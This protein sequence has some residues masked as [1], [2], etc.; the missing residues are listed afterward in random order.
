MQTVIPWTE[1]TDEQHI[2]WGEAVYIL[3]RDESD[4][5]RVSEGEC[6]GYDFTAI[7]TGVL[8]RSEI[9]A[10]CFIKDLKHED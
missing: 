7:G 3:W 5:L 4:R 6:V 2:R 9:R 1:L 8:R 10:I